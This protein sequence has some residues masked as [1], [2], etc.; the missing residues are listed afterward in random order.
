MREDKGQKRNKD[1]STVQTHLDLYV[2]FVHTSYV[3]FETFKQ[4]N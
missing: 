1:T 3:N 2:Q 4:F